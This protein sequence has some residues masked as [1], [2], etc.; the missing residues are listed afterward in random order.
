MNRFVSSYQV[1]MLAGLLGFGAVA[2]G[3]FAAHRLEPALQAL[4]TTD[5]FELAVRYQFY[6]AIA[7]L[8]VGVWMR[9]HPAALPMLVGAV[10]CF[11]GGVACFSGS[12]Y[13]LAFTKS[14]QVWWVTPLGGLLLLAGWLLLM[15]A[16][17]KERQR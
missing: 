16:A 17:W 5:T 2:L 8:A 10:L 6:H 1:L 14:I 3:A 7:L 13:V 15:L 12:L 4:G 11:S 9:T